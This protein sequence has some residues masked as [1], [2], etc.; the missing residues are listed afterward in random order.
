MAAT[1]CDDAAFVGKYQG[2]KFSRGSTRTFVIPEADLPD[3]FGLTETVGAL[4][5]K[6]AAAFL[7]ETRDKLGRCADRDLGTD[8]TPG[9]RL[10]RGDRSFSVWHLRTQLSDERVLTYSMAILRSGTSVGQLSFVRTPEV[11]MTGGA[12][13]DLAL[14]ALDRLGELSRRR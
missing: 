10:D 13:E 8:V 9:R 14:R 1:R 11:G 5:E 6:K 2:S 4:P 3:E 7:A 12:F